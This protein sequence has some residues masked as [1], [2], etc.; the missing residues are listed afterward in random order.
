MG[1]TRILSH[2][3]SGGV[4]GCMSSQ[5]KSDSDGTAVCSHSRPP[6]SPIS[7][8]RH[9]LQ[10]LYLQ[11]CDMRQPRDENLLGYLLVA[12]SALSSMH[13]QSCRDVAST[14]TKHYP[15]VR[16]SSKCMRWVREGGLQEF[17]QCIISEAPQKP[18]AFKLSQLLEQWRWKVNVLSYISQLCFTLKGVQSER[19]E[20]QG[21]TSAFIVQSVL[22]RQGKTIDSTTYKRASKGTNKRR[23]T[24]RRNHCTC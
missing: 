20:L 13:A 8:L 5:F 7:F 14:A 17:T 9:S 6:E 2:T 21:D 15:R 4:T 1:G 23:R 19:F 10:Q 12:S 16:V 3:H 22:H 18:T 24:S 11:P